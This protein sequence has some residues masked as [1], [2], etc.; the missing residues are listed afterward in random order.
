MDAKHEQQIVDKVLNQVRLLIKQAINKNNKNQNKEN[1]REKADSN[2]DSLMNKLLDLER[3]FELLFQEFKNNPVH[4][5]VTRIDDN[6]NNLDSKIKLLLEEFSQYKEK[7]DKRL[8]EL[9]R[10]ENSNNEGSG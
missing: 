1:G 7:T 3:R 8:E 6:L 9:G 2:N 4:E 5:K 10:L